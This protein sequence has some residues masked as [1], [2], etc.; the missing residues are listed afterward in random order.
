MFWGDHEPD[1]ECVFFVVLRDPIDRVGSLYDY[2]QQNPTHRKH[3]RFSG[4]PLSHVM[5]QSWVPGSEL[6]NGQVRQ[7]AGRDHVGRAIDADALENAWQVLM[8]NDIVVG[9]TDQIDDA[10]RK[11]SE[12]LARHIPALDN[13]TNASRRSILDT[14]TIDIIGRHNQFDNLLISRARNYFASER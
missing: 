5:S 13:S 3:S 9:F 2:I 12:R 10:L 14:Q 8:R 6:S 4:M 1:P 7:L 11:L